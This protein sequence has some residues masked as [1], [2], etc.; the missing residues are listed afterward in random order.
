MRRLLLLLTVP[1]VLAGC[2]GGGSNTAADR[3]TAQ[4]GSEG[5][6]LDAQ[7]VSQL[8]ELYRAAR[9]ACGE[10]EQIQ[11][12]RLD[13]TVAAAERIGQQTAPNAVVNSGQL[14]RAQ[15]IDEFIPEMAN[16]LEQCGR[17]EEAERLRGITF[18]PAEDPAEGGQPQS[19]GEDVPSQPT[20]E[21]EYR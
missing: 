8:I 17:T 9:D 12:G 19:E 7:S 11:E 2:G 16:V 1:L 21:S 20:P 4:Q 6:Q 10:S 13:E 5:E 3:G 18:T 15:R 14:E